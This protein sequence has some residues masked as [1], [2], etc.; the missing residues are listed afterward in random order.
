MKTETRTSDYSIVIPVYFNEGRLENTLN[1]IKT[2]VIEKQPGR[3]AEILFVDDG[4]GDGSLI[5]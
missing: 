2:Q 1:E 4:S 3:E 5:A